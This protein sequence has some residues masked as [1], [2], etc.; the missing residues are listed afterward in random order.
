[1]NIIIG[2]FSA[3]T[4]TYKESLQKIESVIE[5]N[6]DCYDTNILVLPENFLEYN[7][8]IELNKNFAEII[9][10]QNIIE[11][12]S[13]IAKK[14]KCFI[15]AGTIPVKRNGNYYNSCNIFDSDGTLIDVYE[16][17]NLFVAN[18]D[19]V[20]YDEESFYTPGNREVIVKIANYNFGVAICYDLRFPEL[21]KSMKNNNVDI[22]VVVAAFTY[23]TGKE[24]WVELLTDV[25]Q[26]NECLVVA[27]D[28]CGQSEC[29]Y[30]CYG[31]SLIVGKD[32]QIILQLNED[33]SD[34]NYKI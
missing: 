12:I 9:E 5:K 23:K 31:H 27:A 1:M 4:R 3:N 33:E 22:F 13:R 7:S 25:A 19:G 28:L 16:K 17:R 32:G 11:Q 26:K 6:Y 29:G 8:S 14:K 34:L 15:F 2:Q 18:I 30:K 20:E 10:K 24:N 21:F